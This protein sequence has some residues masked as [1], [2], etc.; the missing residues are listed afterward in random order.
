MIKK[1]I[2]YILLLLSINRCTRSDDSYVLDLVD[3]IHLDVSDS[4]ARDTDRIVDCIIEY[5][6]QYNVCPITMSK[7]AKA[8]SD[9]RFWRKN[10]YTGCLGLFQI[11][12]RWWELLLYRIDHG[13]LGKYIK[14]NNITNTE[15]YYFRIG[16]N[17]EM[18][19]YIISN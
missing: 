16:Y 17:T 11:S 3:I 8:E 4:R 10:E 12:P 15:K 6:T 14:K 9:Y 18:A 1:L 5:S 7:L 2:W 13:K 19:C